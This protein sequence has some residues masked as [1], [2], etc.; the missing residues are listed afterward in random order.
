MIAEPICCTPK[1]L[2]KRLLVEAARRAIAINPVNKVA[3]RG[4]SGLPSFVS[5]PERIA[6]LTSKYWGPKAITLT[7][8]FMDN[9]E[10]S[11]QDKI[12]EH[13]NAWAKYCSIKF[14]KTSAN[15]QVRIS[16]GGG[17]YW[18][19][20]GTDILSIPPS[21][22]TMNLQGFTLSTPDSEYFRVIRH[23][24]G[25]TL[26]FPHEHMRPDLVAKIDPNKAIAYFRQ[27]QGWNRQEVIQQVLTPLNPADLTT[28]KNQPNS[29][30]V[31][32][33]CYQLP[34]SIMKDGQAFIGGAD[35]DQRDA[36][37]AGQVYP[38]DTPPPPPPP[39]PGGPGDLPQ[40]T[41]EAGTYKLV[42]V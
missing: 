11:L 15:G 32:I 36:A 10:P 33:M 16:R 13:M 28:E 27:T 9:P 31:S 41:L 14:V 39:P 3:S 17:G 30:S 8:S 23:E 19:Y 35:I 22:Q 2:P 5:T 7:V 18:S 29:D 26:G 37:F 6:L 12:L 34:G 42:K 4:V 38:L 25:H 20:L 1:Q 24:T 21:Q 40:F